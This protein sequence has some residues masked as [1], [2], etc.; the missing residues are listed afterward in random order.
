MSEQKP[1]W[2]ELPAAVIKKVA[3]TMDGHT[4]FEPNVLINLGVPEH[5][6]DHYVKTFKSNPNDPKWIIYNADG[7]PVNQMQGVYGLTVLEDIAAA[8]GVKGRGFYG[9]GSQARE[10]QRA[11]NAHFEN[12]TNSGAK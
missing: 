2:A 12:L 8:F 9:R 5:V 10:W 3:E 7:E 6:S 1:N 11:I 4:I